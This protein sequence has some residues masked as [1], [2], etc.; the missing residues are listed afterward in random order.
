MSSSPRRVYNSDKLILVPNVHTR[1]ELI[2]KEIDEL[3]KN[4]FLQRQEDAIN[5]LF[6]DVRDATNSK[7]SSMQELAELV[8][9]RP[10]TDRAVYA[11]LQA[12]PYS[13]LWTEMRQGFPVWYSREV[14]EQTFPP[15]LRV[16]EAQRQYDATLEAVHRHQHN[17]SVFRDA[18]ERRPLST[19]RWLMELEQSAREQFTVQ[20][21]NLDLWRRE[22][23]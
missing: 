16:P 11:I 5:N 21:M 7:V 15:E 22:D 1:A 12:S 9:R 13:Y 8:I 18:Y 10:K 23:R 3:K 2:Q 14:F 4:T 19:L 20:L 17:S 6:K